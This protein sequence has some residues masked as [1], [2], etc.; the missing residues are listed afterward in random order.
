MNYAAIIF[1]LE[2]DYDPIRNEIVIDKTKY[3]DKYGK[4]GISDIN[5]LKSYI[6]NIYKT[7]LYRGIKGVYIYAC[8]E[9]LKRYLK[10]HLVVN[11]ELIVSNDAKANINGVM[12]TSTKSI[13]LIVKFKEING[14]KVVTDFSSRYS[15]F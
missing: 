6:I 2:I 9:N 3:F 12:E 4:N 13:I 14:K 15:S 5:D 8:N 10:M 7:V 1:G 11:S